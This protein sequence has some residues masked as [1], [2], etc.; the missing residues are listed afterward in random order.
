MSEVIDS[1]FNIESRLRSLATNVVQEAKVANG[2]GA[3]PFT[4]DDALRIDTIFQLLHVHKKIEPEY[5]HF[6]L[7]S[8][9]QP[10]SSATLLKISDLLE[11]L[12]DNE[13]VDL[14]ETPAVAVTLPKAVQNKK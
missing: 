9:N 3:D 12:P 13:T 1:G 7:V 10:K 6:P 5:E 2:R 8:E 14:P 4:D 11:H